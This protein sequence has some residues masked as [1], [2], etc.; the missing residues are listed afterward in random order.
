MSDTYLDIAQAAELAKCHPNTI[1]HYINSGELPAG[2]LGRKVVVRR[3]ALEKLIDAKILQ[4]YA[5]R[6]Q[7]LT[8]KTR[9]ALVVRKQVG[10]A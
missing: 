8:R 10:E 1:W 9:P 6:L 4:Q 3:D 5:D 2:G 7:R